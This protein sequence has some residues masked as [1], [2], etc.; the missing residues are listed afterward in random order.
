MVE[1]VDPNLMFVNLGDCD[2][3]GHGDL[4]GT[5]LHAA[6]TA[7]LASADAQVGRFVA[8]L[9]RTGRWRRSVVM[10]LAD[11]SMDWSRP[12]A[13]VSL[14]PA[15]DADPLLAGHVQIA[16][17]GGA[18]LLYW[19]GPADRRTAAVERMRAIAGS[20]P[21]VL[22]THLPARLRLGHR[23]GDVVAY[24]KAGYRFSDP[25]QL[26]NPIPGNHGHPA[27]LPIPFFVSGGSSLVPHGT[28]STARARTADV[29][30]TVGKVFGLG[31]PRGGYDGRARL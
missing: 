11:H 13:L 15:F 31:A 6:R 27:T 5:T 10:V 17:N 14:Q 2:R 16:D 25:N 23:A 22:S 8:M 9:R 24:C 26:S 1:K 20:T 19:T 28:S 18:D 7:A 3:V 29:A 21:G 12:D 4:T 30:P